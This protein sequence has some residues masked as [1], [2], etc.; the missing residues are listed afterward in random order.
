MIY[1]I[2]YPNSQTIV[3]S[4]FKDAVKKYIKNY[5]I[6]N[7]ETRI[8]Q[9]IIADQ[10]NHMNANINYYTQDGRNKMGIDMYPMNNY[11]IQQFIVQGQPV[12]INQ[13]PVEQEFKPKLITEYKKNQYYP[14]FRM[15]EPPRKRQNILSIIPTMEQPLSP[16]FSY[17]SFIPTVFN[18]PINK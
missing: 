17:N 15:S 8:R 11:Q 14:E 5:E 10:N 6:I 2:I 13:P 4:S 7:N 16:M 18:L 1:Y 12:V 3:A 9:M